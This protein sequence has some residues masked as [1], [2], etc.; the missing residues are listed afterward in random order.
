VSATGAVNQTSTVDRGYR[1]GTPA[2]TVQNATNISFTYA[3]L[4]SA[5]TDDGGASCQVRF[6][7]GTTSKTSANF[8]S[9]DTVTAWVTGY[10]INDTPSITILNLV[11]NTVYY[12][13]VEVQ[14][15]GASYISD[16]LYFDTTS[17]TSSLT[18]YTLAAPNG[19]LITGNP[20]MPPQMYQELN[21]SGIPGADIVN[22]ILATSDTPQAVWWFPF[23]FGIIAILGLLAYGLTCK[24]GAAGSELVLVIV[25]EAGL[26]LF[27]LIGSVT[28]GVGMIPFWPAILFPIPAIA[29]IIN[30]QTFSKWG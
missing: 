6:G 27:A 25:I 20:T 22:T 28:S 8:T 5:L 1:I 11:L 14:N 12:F 4:N 19:I 9:Y 30:K 2:I 3:T 24:D 17:Q 26:V 10:N 16:E 29:I 23:I 18:N 13:R 15:A 7:Y 21:P